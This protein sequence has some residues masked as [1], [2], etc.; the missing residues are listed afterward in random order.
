M[1]ALEFA[2]LSTRLFRDLKAW[3]EEASKDDTLSVPDL[4]LLNTT[5]KVVERVTLREVETKP[6]T[7][8]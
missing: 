1:T 8:N 7:S 6:E 3:I 4:A 2:D 5:M